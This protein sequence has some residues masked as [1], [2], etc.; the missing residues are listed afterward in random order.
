MEAVGG[1]FQ[2]QPHRDFHPAKGRNRILSLPLLSELGFHANTSVNNSAEIDFQPRNAYEF[3]R[4]RKDVGGDPTV[5]KWNASIRL[6]NFISPDSAPNCVCV[7]SGAV[8]TK[9]MKGELMRR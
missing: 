7:S 3:M 2:I 6:S 9:S 8:E 5:R 4:K 1:I